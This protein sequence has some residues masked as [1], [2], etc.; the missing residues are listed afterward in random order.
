[1]ARKKSLVFETQ[2]KNSKGSARRFWFLL[3][4]CVL[5]VLI[6]SLAVIMKNSD[7][8]IDTALGFEKETETTDS[9]SET[10]PITF[11]AE[12]VFLLWCAD[13]DRKKVHFMSLV[14]VKLPECRVTVCAVDPDS[15]LETTE[16]GS[17]SPASIYASSGEKALVAALEKAYDI[18][19]DRY[20]GANETDFK[21]FVNNFGGMK[22]TVPEQINYKSDELSLVLIKG[23]QNLKGDTLYKYML[24]LNTRGAEG[25][26][27]QSDAMLDILGGIFNPANTEKRSR[28]FS[29]ITNNMITDITIVDFSAEENG[30]ILLMQNGIVKAETADYPEELS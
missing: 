12:R 21:T 9:V 29:R 14:K 15:V 7:Y 19:I 25:K 30:I 2:N 8:D 22:I 20:V 5:A 17:A 3:V 24:Y 10:Q 26:K 11:E 18:D 27:M 23:N 13:S 4:V 28:I 16:N 6:V 1:M